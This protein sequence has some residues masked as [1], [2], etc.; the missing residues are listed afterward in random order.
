M[1]KIVVPIKQVPETSNV[2]MDPETGTMIRTGVDAII[3]PLDL[4]AIETALQLKEVYKGNVTAVSMGPKTAI[5]SLREALAL[6]CDN[7]ILLS[8]S[9]FRG[10][11]TW[12]TAYTLAR[13]VMK[14]S[15][16][17]IIICGERATDGE[18]GQ[19]GP[20]LAGL[21]GLPLVTYIRKITDVSQG[22]IMLERMIEG[23]IEVVRSRLPL[24][25]TVVKEIANPR[26]PTLRGMKFAKVADI[27]VWG[28]EEIEANPEWIGLKGSPTRVVKIQKSKV[29][30]DG[31][32]ITARKQEELKQAADQLINFLIEKSFRTGE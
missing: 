23:G 17:N 28:P 21:L 2:K 10:A 27:T 9:D 11:D 13:A 15:N 16:V 7:A 32:I 6:G 1:L 22:S 24:L 12:A 14:I 5:S 31:K 26:L 25:L 8:H 4:Y 20:S 30:R 18:T 3:N 29:S 19:V